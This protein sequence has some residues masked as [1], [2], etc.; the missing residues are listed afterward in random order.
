MYLPDT[1]CSHNFVGS[2]AQNGM[3]INRIDQCSL[4]FLIQQS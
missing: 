4:N 1:L 2:L 3:E